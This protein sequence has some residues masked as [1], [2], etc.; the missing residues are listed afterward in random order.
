M[1]HREEE[2]ASF[3]LSMPARVLPVSSLTRGRRCGPGLWM[4]AA[5]ICR[6]PLEEEEE[7]EEGE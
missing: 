3:T 5:V 1:T 6:R 4:G 7:E 2:E